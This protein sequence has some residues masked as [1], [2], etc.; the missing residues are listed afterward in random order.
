MQLDR[1]GHSYDVVV[2][3]AGAAGLRAALEACGS[4]RTAVLS[5]VHPTRSLTGA[6]QAGINAALV[7]E[8]DS[9]EQHA[10]DTVLAGA[11]LVDQEAAALMCQA[12]PA[13][14]R[15]LERFGL[16]F[17]RTADG[18]IRQRRLGAGPVRRAAVAGELTGHHILQTL[19]QQCLRAGVEFFD[20]FYALEL[21]V[22]GGASEAPGAPV[23]GVVGYELAS[24]ELHAFAARS[25]VLATG[26]CGRIFGTT[27]NGHSA[28][29]DAMALAL[30]SGI[31][32]QDMEFFQFHPT[33][34]HPLGII[35]PEAARA[36]GAVLRNA[37]G[38]A[39]MERHSA[40]AKDLAQ[41]DVVARAIAAEISEGRGNAPGGDH[42]VLD[43]TQ[44]PRERWGSATAT[45][46][47]LALTQLGIDAAETPLPVRPT[48]HYAMGGIGTTTG[49]HV[50]GPDE[51][52]VPGLYAAGE[53]ACVSVHGANRLAANGLLEAIVFGQRAGAAAAANARETSD[54]ITL[55]AG[56]GQAAE[57]LIE[58]LRDPSAAERSAPLRDALQRTMDANASVI[59]SEASLARA[60]DDIAALKERYGRVGASDPDRRYNTDLMEAVELGFLLDVAE[61]LVASAA[62]RRESRGA[63]FRSD[64]PDRDD[65]GFLHHTTAH[66]PA[67]AGRPD[68]PL[69]LH[70]RPVDLSRHQ[71][72]ERE[73]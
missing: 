20:E 15:D 54:A 4:A 70:A 72:A 49:A 9:W 22:A 32:L 29:G 60:M 5:K 31:P 23:T 38:E 24:G 46:A 21:L 41:T 30:R 39:F 65:V 12:A 61:V 11:F 52:P 17:S 64:H 71:P 56:A 50:L 8:G 1:F 2:V 69:H 63:H 66:R 13:A 44:L 3:G 6:A 28:T 47:G 57:A 40:A 33:G 34:L 18:F 43:L 10:Y 27:S 37:A 36:E 19:Y 7:G 51:L 45:A 16:P 26:G 73:Y 59:R 25:V 48:A 67:A 62:A 58:R 14:V 42:V 55:P 68:A 35:V 53:A